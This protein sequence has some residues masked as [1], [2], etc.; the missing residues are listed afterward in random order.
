M[1]SKKIE[2]NSSGEDVYYRRDFSSNTGVD[3]FGNKVTQDLAGNVRG[4]AKE[5]GVDEPDFSYQ[6]KYTLKNSVDKYGNYVADSVIDDNFIESLVNQAKTLIDSGVMI[7]NKALPYGE[8]DLQD[9]NMTEDNKKALQVILDIYNNREQIMN[10]KSNITLTT[11]ADKSEYSDEEIDFIKTVSE[12]LGISAENLI[13]NIKAEN[14]PK[15]YVCLCCNTEM[16]DN[17]N[18][19]SNCGSKK[20]LSCNGCGVKL[21]ENNNFCPNCGFKIR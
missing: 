16:N 15:K 7:V 21:K 11:I 6:E 4:V 18:F 12:Q 20:V 19:C 8:V 17:D 1:R 2:I 13:A 10:K 9:E 14:E 3:R 5:D